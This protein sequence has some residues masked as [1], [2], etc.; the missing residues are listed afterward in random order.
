[1]SVEIMYDQIW[2][3]FFKD[4][5]IISLSELN[6]NKKILGRSEWS[7]WEVIIGL[8]LWGHWNFDFVD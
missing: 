7:I 3:F 6:E 4:L 1:M 8:E 2:V 5:W